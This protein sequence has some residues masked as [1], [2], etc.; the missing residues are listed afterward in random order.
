MAESKPAAYDAVAAG[1]FVAAAGR[2]KPHTKLIA[3]LAFGHFVI[4]V[5]QGSLPALLPFLK[6]H[7]ALS[8]AQAAMILLAANLTSSIIQPLFGWVSDQI[9]QR[10]ILPVSVFVSGAGIA[11]LGLAPGYTAVLTLVVVM[12][13]GVAAWHPEGYKTATGVAGDRKATA[14]SWFSL[15][16]NVGIALGPPLITFL[17]TGIGPEGTLGM[18]LPAVLVGMLLVAVLPMISREAAPV[19]TPTAVRREGATMPRAMALLILVVSIRAWAS[20][21]FTTFVPFYYVDTLKAD[22]TIV[23][24]LL[25]VFLGAGALGT[26]VAGPIADRVGPRAFMKW[27]LLAAAPFGVLFLLS[28]GPLAFVMLALYGGVLTS[29]F[30]VSIVLGQSYLPR[31]A[32]MASGLIVGFA[33]GLGGAGVTALGWVADHWGVPTALW[34]SAMMP[35]VA[36]VPTRFLPAPREASA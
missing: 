21:G 30:S 12:G 28:R 16:G 6:Q 32:G 3:L 15:G 34:I 14:L 20:F 27:V 26:V 17:V 25:F 29:S 24:V 5:N 7:H 10:W 9:A 22:P 2:V 23:G 18:L 4:D 31:H 1:A 8:Y 36:F 19:R 13:L 33:I 11:L 35:L